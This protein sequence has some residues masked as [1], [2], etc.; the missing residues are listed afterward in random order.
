[1]FNTSSNHITAYLWICLSGFVVDHFDIK[2]VPKHTSHQE[3]LLI[4]LG[5]PYS[6][7]I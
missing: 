1:M 5:Q 6:Y 4:Q 3:V 7:G 2:R